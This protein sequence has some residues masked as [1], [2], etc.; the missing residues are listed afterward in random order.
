MDK[1]QLAG[2]LYIARKLGWSREEIGK[3]S[4]N[5]FNEIFSELIFQEQQDEYQKNHRVASLMATIVNCTPR[6]D[7]R[8]YKASDFIGNPP[9]RGDNKISSLELAKQR[10]LKVPSREKQTG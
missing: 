9:Q 5:Q 4:P 8:R 7:T 3:L 6:K 1:S 2:I 10:G